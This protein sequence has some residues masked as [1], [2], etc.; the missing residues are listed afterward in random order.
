VNAK[1]TFWT[2]RAFPFHSHFL[3]ARFRKV[4]R[5]DHC[6][7]RSDVHLGLPSLPSLKTYTVSTFL[8][9]TIM[10]KQ[11][12]QLCVSCQASLARAHSLSL[13]SK[14]EGERVYLWRPGYPNHCSCQRGSRLQISPNLGNFCSEF[15]DMRAPLDFWPFRNTRSFL[16]SESLQ[17][18]FLISD[19]CRL[20]A[21]DTVN[22]EIHPVG[23]ARFYRYLHVEQI[24]CDQA[25]WKKI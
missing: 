20:A 16:I 7:K 15:Q 24:F 17:R 23:H 9:E 6:Q 21:Q 22:Q 8:G 10:T 25:R 14:Y 2:A 5:K 13:S 19:R 3:S 11:S 4:F 18:S 1:I 12:K